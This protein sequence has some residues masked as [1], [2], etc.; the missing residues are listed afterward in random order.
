MAFF[1]SLG[2]VTALSFLSGVVRW[3]WALLVALF[4]LAAGL[5]ADTLQY[6]FDTDHISRRVDVW[7]I[8]PALLRHM[9]VLHF[10]FCFGF[11]LFVGD[12]FHRQ[13]D[14]GTSTLF[15]V[16][17]PSRR[18]Y[19][20][21]NMGAIGINA[22]LFMLA[23]WLISLFVGFIMVP[24][25]SLWPMV[26]RDTVRPLAIPLQMPIP[27]FSFLLALY[28]AWGLWIAGSVVMLVSTFFKN[29]AV[30]LGTITGWVLL[31]LALS[32][33]TYWPWQRFVYIGELIGHHKHFGERAISLPTFFLGSS[34]MLM[35]IALIGSWRMR[36]EEV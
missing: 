6:L 4:A 13:R 35:A 33:N 2:R 17:M 27:V 30:L 12:H 8:F 31:S 22:F 29:T 32:W 26:S 16:R 28:T 25:S 20:L 3:R 18:L 1:R 21:G 5:V 24:P 14:L 34:L 7:D 36:R 10:L 9:Y 15:A 23:C 11:L 19:W